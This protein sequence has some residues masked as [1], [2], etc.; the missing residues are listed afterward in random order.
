MKPIFSLWLFLLLGISQ[1]IFS[2]T[3]W[4]KYDAIVTAKSTDPKELSG[5][6]T[7]NYT[8]PQEK[9]EAI[10]YWITHN[11]AY[12]FRL[13]AK[14]MKEDN[15]KPVKYTAEGL[16]A[17]KDDEIA[18]ALKRKKGV[19]QNYALTFQ[20]L[21]KHANIECEYIGGWSKSSPE[22]S[23]SMGNKHAWNAVNWGD[24]WKLVDPTWGSGY[25]NNGKF[26]FSF[27]TGFF[28]TDQEVF[29]LNHFPREAKWQ[30]LDPLISEETFETYPTIGRAFL[31]HQLRDLSPMTNTLE[32]KRGEPVEISFTCAKELSNFACVNRK[33]NALA[34]HELRKEGNKYTVIVDGNKLRS[35]LYSFWENKELLFYYKLRVR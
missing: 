21:C 8:S 28:D 33:T 13:L 2:Q 34:K 26:Q 5:L 14:H 22:R 17:M 1:P 11:I 23:S 27:H 18:Y 31:D 25:G 29:V 15:N 19:C 9:V 16:Q 7:S 12:D 6:I 32:V 3:D 10:Y 30:L 20:A 4:T 24:G 35:G